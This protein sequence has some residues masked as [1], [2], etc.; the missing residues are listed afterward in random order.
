[1]PGLLLWLLA[2]DV[3]LPDAD[4]VADMEVVTVV[5]DPPTAYPLETLEVTAW[6]ADAYQRGADVMIWPCTPIELGARVRCAEGVDIAGDGIPLSYWV[7]QATVDEHHATVRMVTPFL[8]YTVFA[9][10]TVGRQREEGLPMPVL[11][12]ACDPGVC[13]VFDWV[14]ADPAPGTEAYARVARALAD[15]TQLA[16]QA[17]QEQMSL[18]VKLVYVTE[19]GSPRRTNPELDVR[20]RRGLPN[21]A[22]FEWFVDVIRGDDDVPGTV[23]DPYGPYYPT[24]TTDDEPAGGQGSGVMSVRIGYTAGHLLDR[25][26]DGS[27]LSLTWQGEYER[28]GVMVI[29]LSDGQGGSAGVAV[30]LPVIP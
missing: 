13:E 4:F 7:H 17:E 26:F 15:S 2:C 29:G 24:T 1:M 11:V 18:A 16:L 12:L 9:E 8:P 20:A 5:V 22:G 23:P 6:V 14:A 28:A 10:E 30:E 25:T 21:V 3:R 27:E 19:P